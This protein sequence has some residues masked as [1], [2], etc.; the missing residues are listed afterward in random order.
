[1]ANFAPVVMASEVAESMTDSEHNWVVAIA[2]VVV[3]VAVALVVVAAVDNRSAVGCN[4]AAVA[5]V[6]AVDI[7]LVVVASCSPLST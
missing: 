2:A 7:G 5:V 1:V 6:V 3:V 4:W